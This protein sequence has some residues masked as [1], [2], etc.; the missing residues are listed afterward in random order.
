MFQP[1][2]PFRIALRRSL[3]FLDAWLGSCPRGRVL[4]G[5]PFLFLACFLL[6]GYY[7]FGHSD[8][9][10]RAG[11]LDRQLA[12]AWARDDF[13][14]ALLLVQRQLQSSPESTQLK[15]ELARV[16]AATGEHAGA[17]ELM[18]Q[19][20][21]A[22]S[23]TVP[24]ELEEDEDPEVPRQSATRMR[25]GDGDVRAAIWLIEHEYTSRQ[26]E[27]LSPREQQEYTGLLEWVSAA[28]PRDVRAKQLFA[29]ALLQSGR[30]RESLPV[31]VSLIP[32]APGIG[33][34]A[35][36]VARSLG[37]EER[38]D[39][40]ARES[41]ARFTQLAQQEPDD[42]ALAMAVARCQ[43]F[44]RLYPDAFKTIDGAILR[45]DSE[46]QR[47]QLG[48]VLAETIVTWVAALESKAE[49]NPTERLRILRLLQIAVQY[50][51]NNG[52]V[53]QAVAKQVLRTADDNDQQ[54]A[55]IRESLTRGTSPGISHFI[56]GTAAVM[57][58]DYDAAAL[59]LELAAKTLPQSGVILN[60]LA[61]V[62]SRQE[63]ADLQRALS[64]AE[65]AIK[66]TPNATPH[67]YETRGQILFKMGRYLDAVA[68]LEIALAV[69]E[70]APGVHQSLAECY[71]QLGNDDLSE[72]HQRAAKRSAAGA[73]EKQ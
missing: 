25:F 21:F 8:G 5:L 58:E 10:A 72:Q 57:K 24:V 54:I 62:L 67:F 4:R 33:L 30:L 14:T 15:F 2:G 26:W 18:R 13:D 6:A 3:W 56:K 20:A 63:D 49:E 27:A 39:R 40:Y 22:G 12:R 19:L 48:Q 46:Q 32:T 45:S 61:F 34:R 16:R 31:L 38:A 55:A 42:A 43:L 7:F 36:M 17:V 68:D 64:V 52:R 60:N 1:S 9:G 29:E 47:Q 37:D 69:A 73:A 59:H 66:H 71:K 44:L 28:Q 53:L 11:L 23:V 51:P 41:L 70:L 35:G 50:A 65:A